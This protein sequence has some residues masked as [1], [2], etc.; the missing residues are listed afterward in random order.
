M[1]DERLFDILFASRIGRSK[2]IEQVRI[3]KDLRSEVRV[4]GRQ[5]LLE[6][7]RSTAMAC[8]RLPNDLKAENVPRPAVLDGLR[9][10]PTQGGLRF[11]GPSGFMSSQS[12]R[13]ADPCRLVRWQ[14]G[15]KLRGVPGVTGEA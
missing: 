5:R 14:R 4:G 1:C 12:M 8:M 2:E 6:V 7:V 15:E 13:D 11:R 3:L 10:I 9:R